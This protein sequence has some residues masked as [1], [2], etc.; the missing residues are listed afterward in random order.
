MEL[1]K[2]LE[3]A[4]R[5]ALPLMLAFDYPTPQALTDCILALAPSA[6]TASNPAP[7]PAS[8]YI[9][10]SG[11]ARQAGDS[12]AQEGSASVPHWQQL[13]GLE[14]QQYVL[15][16]VMPDTVLHP[17]FCLLHEQNLTLCTLT[18]LLGCF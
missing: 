16:Q 8:E 18:L 1:R 10:Q 9:A 12:T 2:D 7:S 13:D 11:S 4:T 6:A 3:A 5:L 17:L 15:Q 14:R